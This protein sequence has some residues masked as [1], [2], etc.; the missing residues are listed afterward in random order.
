MSYLKTASENMAL[1]KEEIKF[2]TAQ[3]NALVIQS[4]RGKTKDSVQFIDI[5]TNDYVKFEMT[6]NDAWNAKPTQVRSRPKAYFIE[7]NETEI[8][9][10]LKVLGIDIVYLTDDKS[11]DVEVYKVK[12]YTR[13]SLP[14]EKMKLQTVTV[15]LQTETR[16]FPKGTAM[17]LMNQRRANIVPEVLEPE[18][19]SSFISFG[20]LRTTK[21]AILPIY[22]LLN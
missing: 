19:P 9:E 6:I 14:Y 21:D 13:Q 5:N 20:V 12:S 16:T 3:E 10:K 18:A 1:V 2:A 4:K 8:I 17:V 15:E 7:A 22:R 11:H